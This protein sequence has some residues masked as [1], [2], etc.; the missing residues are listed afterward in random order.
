MNNYKNT[1]LH[2]FRNFLKAPLTLLGVDLKKLQ[3]NK[4]CHFANYPYLRKGLFLLFLMPFVSFALS[5]PEVQLI[6]TIDEK[7]QGNEFLQLI[8]NTS[9]VVEDVE[10]S[11]YLNNL[12]KELVK[13]STSPN[14]HFEFFFL[15]DP[16]IN[17]FTGSYGYIGVYTGMLLSS[18]SE[19]ELAGVLSHEIAHVTQNHLLRSS[20]K[21]KKR[22]YLIAAGVLAAVLVDNKKASEAIFTSTIAGTLQSNINFTR[23]NEWEADRIG[24]NILISSAFD[25]RGMADFFNKLKDSK[26]AKEF[27]RSHPLSVNRISDSTQRVE[28]LTGDYRQDSFTYKTVKARLYYAKNQHIKI[29]KGKEIRYYMQAYQAFKKQSYQQAKRYID[30]LLALNNDKSSYIL[31]GRIASKL[32][33][34]KSAQQYFNKNTIM[35]ND[36]ASMY[37]AAKAYMDNKQLQLAASTLKPFLRVNQ[38]RYASYQ[39]LSMIYLRQGNF[40]RAHIQSAK[41]LILQ[42]KLKQAIGH[43]QRAKTLTNSQDLYDVINVKIN[44]LKRT[45]KLYRH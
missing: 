14:K 19:S 9:K 4:I 10:I 37:Y 22:S 2:Q 18:E 15:R 34:I 24:T 13:H 25:P 35:K 26:N 31:A 43:Y 32:G 11:L 7:R 5:V 42:G 21:S 36:E 27:L 33:D 39:L 1:I 30:K 12:G 28:G 45:V 23:E 16:S 40:G 17:A 41:G 20:K 6:E 3:L 38:G 8:W 29:E 44:A